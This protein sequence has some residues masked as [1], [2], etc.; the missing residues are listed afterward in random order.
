MINYNYI[1]SRGYVVADKVEDFDDLLRNEF[2]KVFVLFQVF[3]DKAVRKK[4][5][6]LSVHCC[7]KDKECLWIGELRNLQVTFLTFC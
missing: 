6:N 1:K 4:I 2:L 7:F 3:N 5:L